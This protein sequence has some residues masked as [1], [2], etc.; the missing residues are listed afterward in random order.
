MI[1]PEYFGQQ[2]SIQTK[3]VRSEIGAGVI[4]CEKK[5][6]NW[7]YYISLGREMRQYSRAI[8]K[9]VDHECSAEPVDQEHGQEDKCQ[10][11]Q[12]EEQRHVC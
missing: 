10:Q 9:R 8:T 6:I 11:W 1:A 5:I 7:I 3:S 12:Y 2:L 4:G